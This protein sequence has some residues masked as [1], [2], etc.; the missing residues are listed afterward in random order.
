[1]KQTSRICIILLKHLYHQRFY[2]TFVSAT[3]QGGH[4]EKGHE[5]CFDFAGYH[6]H[7]AYSCVFLYQIQTPKRR[8]K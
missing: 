8:R 3:C 1:M 2:D 7:P 5:D 6:T 4:H